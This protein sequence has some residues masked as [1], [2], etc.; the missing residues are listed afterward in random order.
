MSLL[1]F[2]ATLGLTSL[3]QDTQSNSA[4]TIVSEL[5]PAYPELARSMRLEGTVRLRVTVTPKGTA[6][7]VETI[8]GNPVLAEAAEKAVSKWTWARAKD[9]S[10][11][12]VEVSFHL[13]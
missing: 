11:E 4:R 1:L 10:K 3:A 5:R 6:K 7:S 12:F 9:E 13:H 2:G 8:G